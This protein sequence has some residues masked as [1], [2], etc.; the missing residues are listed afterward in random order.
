MTSPAREGG[1]RAAWTC[2]VLLALDPVFWLASCVVRAET[3]LLA[4]SSLALW[5]I[6]RLPSAFPWKRFLIGLLL[7]I[8]FAAHPNALPVSL[9]IFTFWMIKEPFSG[10]DLA[11]SLAGLFCGG[12]VMIAFF[13][14]NTLRMSCQTLH[15]QM[16]RPPLFTWPW[17]PMDWLQN[18]LHKLFMTETYY[19][20]TGKAPG[21]TT[22]LLLRSA[23]WGCLFLGAL[24]FKRIGCG[25]SR[26]FPREMRW[27]A[28]WLATWISMALLVRKQE[29][30]YA[31]NFYPFLLP[32]ISLYLSDS[33]EH[34]GKL[35][36]LCKGSA[37]VMLMASPFFFARTV[38]N[39]VPIAPSP[40]EMFR[41]LRAYLPDPHVKI[42]GPNLFW[43]DKEYDHFRDIGA[44]TYSH[45]Y[46]GGGRDAG[47]WLE[48][49]RPD[50]LITDDA[51]DRIFLRNQT[52]VQALSRL[53]GVPA[54]PLGTI[55]TGIGS[56]G[57]FT[58][59]RL[60]WPS[61]AV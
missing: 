39:Y 22:C 19:F 59:Y 3:I 47:V 61:D 27:P 48:K 24:G 34:S 15:F 38:Y 40:A 1:P 37:A 56:Y 45:W 16:M 23:G 54:T 7:G 17:S 51:F 43:Y 4:V 60:S 14:L 10:K 44:L 31:L 20:S 32:F 42:V 46:T 30:L 25:Q 50:I 36:R 26:P 41:Q 58:V 35:H 2:A 8:L 11:G 28:G 53:L 49:W 52:S 21:W 18:A 5:L 33:L 55:E 29:V 9:G 6:L 57:T 13:D 12:M